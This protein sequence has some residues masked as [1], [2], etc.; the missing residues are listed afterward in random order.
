M[1]EPK[2]EEFGAEDPA[3]TPDGDEPYPELSELVRDAI[4]KEL[5]S[6]ESVETPEE[7]RAESGADDAQAMTTPTAESGKLATDG[8]SEDSAEATD[9]GIDDS[10]SELDELREILM[11]DDASDGAPVSQLPGLIASVRQELRG[12]FEQQT[13]VLRTHSCDTRVI[14]E[15]LLS[16]VRAIAQTL[17]A[18]ETDPTE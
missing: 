2:R 6:P 16:H 17:N 9:A 7:K 3:G 14:L 15:E 12:A 5:S 18:L 8:A 11:G 10:N 4:T 1:E 13:E